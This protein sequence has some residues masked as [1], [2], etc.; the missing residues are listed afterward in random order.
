M[1][2]VPKEKL[3]PDERRILTLRALD[4]EPV[5]ALA[6]EFDVSRAWIYVLLEDV[7]NHHEEKLREI[8]RE[9]EFLRQARKIIEREPL[10]DNAEPR[11][12]GEK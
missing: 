8:E 2:N 12:E 10:G 5:S 1:P 7:R 6:R 11:A 4:G 3:T 9:G